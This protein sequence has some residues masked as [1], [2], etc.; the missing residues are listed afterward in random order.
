MGI[1]TFIKSKCTQTAV[2]WGNPKNDG[3]GK[4]TF[5]AMQ[6]VLVSWQDERGNYQKAGHSRV[7]YVKDKKELFA[8]IVV[9]SVTLPTGGWDVD[10]YLYLGKLSTLP[11]GALP[12]DVADAWEIK[13][14]KSS[15]SNNNVDEILYKLS[16]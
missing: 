1:K 15:A 5:G 2:Y 10:G 13:D 7:E 16:L 3:R 4:F 8:S 11:I 9:Y 6:E 14:I 12:Y